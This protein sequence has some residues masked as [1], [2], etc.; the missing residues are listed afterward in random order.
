MLV[1][2]GFVSM[3]RGAHLV[4]GYPLLLGA[5]ERQCLDICMMT[6]YCL[7]VDYDASQRV[8]YVHGTTSYC[9]GLFTAAS[10]NHYQRV[11]CVYGA[12]NA[13]IL[14]EIYQSVSHQ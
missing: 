4:G 2:I 11:P 12:W 9:G 3:T 1:L 10:V 5:S 6:S 13:A 7:A 14:M 8:C